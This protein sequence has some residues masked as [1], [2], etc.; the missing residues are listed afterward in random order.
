PEHR[1]ID[2]R[3]ARVRCVAARGAVSLEMVATRNFHDYGVNR[4]VNLVH[5][6]FLYLQE[7]RPEYLWTNF[8]APE[9]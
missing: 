4:V 7:H 9:E 8:A 5:E 3:R 1:R 2:R 6:V